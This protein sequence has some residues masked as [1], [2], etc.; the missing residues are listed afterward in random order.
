MKKKKKL[1]KSQK[2]KKELRHGPARSSKPKKSLHSFG[3]KTNKKYGQN[4]LK[5]KEVVR[6]EI[7]YAELKSNDTVLEIGPGT[8]SLTREIVSKVNQTVLIEIDRQF[9]DI[10]EELRQ[11]KN[12]KISI[13]WDDATKASVIKKVKVNKVISNLPY[14]KTIP[15]LFNLLENLDFEK[16]V[17]IIQS[18]LAKRFVARPGGSGYSRISVYIQSLSGVNLLNTIH[19]RA[20]YPEPEVESATIEVLPFTDDI[21]VQELREIASSYKD[22]LE[23]CFNERESSLF[24][25]LQKHY[26]TFAIPNY[27]SKNKPIYKTDVEVFKEV[28]LLLNS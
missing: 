25:I 8:G 18:D 20:F 24:E 2:R 4:F 11:K 15:I 7:E 21:T 16:G 27:V 5:D 26:P 28:F 14:N 22:F 6:A 3:V 1:S 10:L 9:R 23:I 13:I 12:S 17:F 19:P